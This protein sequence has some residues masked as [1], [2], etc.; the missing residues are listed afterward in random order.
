MICVGILAFSAALK[1]PDT[2]APGRCQI[3]S[4]ESEIPAYSPR[5]ACAQP[6]KNR[7][8]IRQ[9][10]RL[11]GLCCKSGKRDNTSFGDGVKQGGDI[12]PPL[13]RLS[14]WAAVA[15]WIWAGFATSDVCMG[16]ESR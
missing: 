4:K 14:P 12:F 7:C 2:E 13:S 10:T 3:T 8:C 1:N 15:G 6:G 16:E 9:V 5:R 11:A